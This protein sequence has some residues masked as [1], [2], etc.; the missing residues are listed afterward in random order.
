MEQMNLLILE[1]MMQQAQQAR[2]ALM[3]LSQD[4]NYFNLEHYRRISGRFNLRQLPKKLSVSGPLLVAPKCP[5]A[6][7]SVAN[8]WVSPLRSRNSRKCLIEAIGAAS[9]RL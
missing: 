9:T 2:T 7:S 5:K 6:L 8:S 4:L 1:K 3:A